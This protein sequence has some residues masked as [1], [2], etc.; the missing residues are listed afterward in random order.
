MVLKYFNIASILLFM[1][2]NNDDLLCIYAFKRVNIYNFII[3]RPKSIFLN[4]SNIIILYD[5]SQTLIVFHRPPQ[6]LYLFVND[7]V[8]QNISLSLGKYY[9]IFN[10]LRIL[11]S[12]INIV[13]KKKYK[14][15]LIFNYD[16]KF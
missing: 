1:I 3:I 13:K 11:C 10:M 4:N 7:V 2:M 15:V 14:F 12:C 6:I 5:V 8:I 9:V 16:F